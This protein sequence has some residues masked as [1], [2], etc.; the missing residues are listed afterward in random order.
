[1]TPAASAVAISAPSAA[2]SVLS[3]G[4]PAPRSRWDRLGIIASVG[5]AVHCLVAPFLLLLLPTLGSVWSHP[6]AHWVLAAL[7]LPLAGVV[8]WRGYR[9]HRKRLA[10]VAMG[11]GAMFILAGLILP[12]WPANA[13]AAVT[14]ASANVVHASHA[15]GSPP[16]ADPAPAEAC[17][18]ACCPTIVQD[19]E[20]G[21]LSMTLPPASLVTIVGSVLL[22]IAHAINLWGCRCFA[23]TAG[24]DAGTCGCHS[25]SSATA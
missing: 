3:P 8:I 6:A 21:S 20:T 15:A 2:E 4:L 25:Q 5:C 16:A 1:M 14:P 18:E 10:L 13:D 22:V 19:A 11:L 7:V 9:L 24:H 17:T 12:V 23:A